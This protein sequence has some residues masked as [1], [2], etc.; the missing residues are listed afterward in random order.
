MHVKKGDEEGG[1][2]CIVTKLK[3]DSNLDKKK[4]VRKMKFEQE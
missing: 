1:G 4:G 3:V 2:Y